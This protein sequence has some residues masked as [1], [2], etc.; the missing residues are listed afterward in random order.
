[1]HLNLIMDQDVQGTYNFKFT[2]TPADLV[3]DM[4]L[5]NA[6]LGKEISHGVLRVAKVEKLQKEENDR[7][8]LDE[9]KALAGELQSVSRPLSYAKVGEV[10]AIL[11]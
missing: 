10:K 1:M 2:D 8:S 5:K 3:L 6:G 4:I 7:K 11:E 9:A